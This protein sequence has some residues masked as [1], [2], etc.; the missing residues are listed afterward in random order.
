MNPSEIAVEGDSLDVEMHIYESE[1][2]TIRKVI[3]PG[4]DRTRDHMMRRELYTIP[5]E[6]FSRSDIIRTQQR[7]SQL[8]YFDPQQITPTPIPNPPDG[9]VDI[10]WDL[11][12]KSHDQIQLSADW[13]GSYAFVGTLGLTLNNF[14]LRNMIKGKFTPIPV[15]D[16]QKLSLSAQANGRLFQSYSFSFTE[17]WLG[18]K[19][20]T[21][22]TVGF[23]FSVLR[24]RYGNDLHVDGD[25]QDF[26]EVGSV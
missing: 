1:Q 21:S 19:K 23:N 26:G 17:P 24:A 13:G 12:E 14:S 15:G 6:K 20:P 4:N 3:I 5:G 10:K 7:F 11:M 2:A 16:G 18:G 22:F 9:T 25:V 8:G